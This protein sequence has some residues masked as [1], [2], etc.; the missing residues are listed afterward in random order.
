MIKQTLF[1]LLLIGG[2]TA[3]GQ[4]TIRAV[5][6]RLAEQRG[7][8][9]SYSSD[10]IDLDKRVDSVFSTDYDSCCRQL[11]EHMKLKIDETDTHLIVAPLAKIT[12]RGTVVDAVTRESLPYAHILVKSASVGTITNRDGNFSFSVDRSLLG[13]SIGF[14]YLG[15]KSGYLI[16]EEM[17]NKV[18]LVEMIP[19]PYSLSDIYVLPNGNTA[20]DIVKQAV[21]NIKRTYH[22]KRLQYEAFYRNTSFKGDRASELI[23][24]ALT[25]DDRGILTRAAYT[26]M[27]LNQFRKS[28]SYLTKTDT[29][30][31]KAFRK[32]F[33]HRNLFR[34]AYSNNHV[35]LYNV[36]WW[37]RPLADFHN[38]SYNLVG[39]EWLDT[40]KVYK[41]SFAYAP[42]YK[43]EKE[44]FDPLSARVE[45]YIYINSED[46]GIVKFQQCFG[47]LM[48][49]ESKKIRE[50]KRNICN[51]ASYQKING[52]YCMKYYNNVGG[53]RG[54]L[55]TYVDSVTAD[56]VKR[57]KVRQYSE[58][59]L[60]MTK[61]V[62]DRKKFE[63]IRLKEQVGH[64]EN[65]Y[66]KVYKYDS[67]FWK[68]YTPLKENPLEEKLID[69]MEWEKS[70]EMQFK[71]NS[72]SSVEDEGE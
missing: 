64:R 51:E 62:T 49:G 69:D 17:E 70:L 32:M 28:K 6:E 61:V 12:I 26:K 11:A 5:V 16:I 37:Y 66:D 21:K 13:D 39:S 52:K 24:A 2:F 19:K 65:S 43:R 67:L 42:D 40:V 71:E 63:R 58:T 23:E 18:H 36:S 59:T 31:G 45:G 54:D 44:D 30:W 68:T 3:K 8:E 35:R 10:L 25:I 14:S 29:Y 57:V 34:S 53:S 50:E 46:F 55:Y 33:G 1:L 15:Y 47:E 38:F 20:E 27:R 4:Q 22:R 60:L 9:I 48:K 56:G 41:I 72:L 7:K